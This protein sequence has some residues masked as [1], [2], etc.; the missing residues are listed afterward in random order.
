[1][2]EDKLRTFCLSL[3]RWSETNAQCLDFKRGERKLVD[4]D[5]SVVR[6]MVPADDSVLHER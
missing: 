5:V 2:F 4:V 6:V 3:T 1:M